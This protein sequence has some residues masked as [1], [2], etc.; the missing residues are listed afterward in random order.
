MIDATFGPLTPGGEIDFSSPTI[1]GTVWDT[2]TEAFPAATS[3]ATVALIDVGVSRSHPNLK[4]RLD[5]VKSIDLVSH[6][7]GA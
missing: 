3:P 4:S 2:I 7:Y 5:A 6:P 1:N